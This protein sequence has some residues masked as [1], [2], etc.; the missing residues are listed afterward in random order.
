MN[1]KRG[2]HFTHV[3]KVAKA[4]KNPVLPTN[5]QDIALAS[6]NYSRDAK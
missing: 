2:G 6:S 4:V 1:E 3:T 5:G